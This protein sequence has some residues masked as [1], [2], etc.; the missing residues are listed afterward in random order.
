MSVALSSRPCALRPLVVHPTVFTRPERLRWL[1]LEMPMIRADICARTGWTAKQT[2]AA[3]EYALRK[4]YVVP[5]NEP[6]RTRR[7]YAVPGWTPVLQH[8]VP[9]TPL[10]EDELQI[11]LR[12]MEAAGV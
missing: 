11:L 8:A 7:S 12:D 2:D 1:L 6:G 4:G 9:G 10:S 5:L 3:L